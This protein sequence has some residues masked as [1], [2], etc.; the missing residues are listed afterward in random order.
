MTVRELCNRMAKL[1]AVHPEEDLEIILEIEI[2]PPNV[3]PVSSGPVRIRAMLSDCGTV[4]ARA[5]LCLK[6]EV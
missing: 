2:N 6:G 1:E 3:V 5:L 4:N